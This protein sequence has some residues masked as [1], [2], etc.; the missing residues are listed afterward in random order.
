MNISA[1]IVLITWFF[2]SAW[3]GDTSGRYPFSGTA[4]ISFHGPFPTRA[5]CIV[6]QKDTKR[7]MPETTDCWEWPN[8]IR[9]SEP[10]R[11]RAPGEIGLMWRGPGFRQWG[12]RFQQ[13][14]EEFPK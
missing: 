14:K 8:A 10:L 11:L 9:V 12:E 1:K 5:M 2:A 6:D 3:Y 7:R 13:F 4:F